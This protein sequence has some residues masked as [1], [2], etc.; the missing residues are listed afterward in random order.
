M[1]RPSSQSLRSWGRAAPTVSRAWRVETRDDVLAGMRAAGPRGL[2]AR[3]FGR[4]YGDACLNDGGDV[5]DLTPLASIHSFDPE[6][7]VLHCDAGTSFRAIMQ[8]CVPLGWQPHICPGTATIS[9][10]GAIANDVHG[11]NHHG[12]GSFGD[13]LDWFELLMPDGTVRR[14]TADS[15]PDLFAATL[16]GIGLTGVILSVQFRLARIPSNAMDLREV[17]VR[18]L[19][20]FLELLQ[21]AER[22]YPYV[23][24]WIDGLTKGRTM[25]RGILELA[26]PAP[27]SVPE[28]RAF[29]VSIPFDFPTW[30]LNR[31]SISAFNALY[32]RRVPAAGRARRVHVNGFLYPL[33]ALHQ[34][35]RMYGRNGVYQFQ[36]VVPF[37]EGRRALI[38]LMEATVRSP[39]PSFLGVLKS[40][41]RRGRGM[42]SFPMPGFVLALDFART[43]ESTRLVKRLQD[44]ALKYDGRV[45]LAKDACL[46]PAELRAMYPEVERFKAVLKRVDPTELMQSGM[47]R[48]LDLSGS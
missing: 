29:A 47:S 33:D 20:S 7:G 38:E 21:A 27:E 42:L 32:Y 24:G 26:R 43:P 36:C 25:G 22:D 17:R 6:T 16:G 3:G 12:A 41:G 19:D 31:Y 1:I 34:W 35:N 4:S 23:V 9:M 30:V 10:G 28:P 18:D 39:T 44:I 8:H 2:I 14:I 37:A 48:R 40:M 5:L 11:K 13:H 45:Y 15:D 46:T